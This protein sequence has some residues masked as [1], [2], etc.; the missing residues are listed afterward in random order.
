M[1]SFIVCG[2]GHQEDTKTKTRAGSNR[3]TL[4]GIGGV[5]G[6]FSEKHVTTRGHRIRCGCC[7]P[8]ARPLKDTL[9]SKAKPIHT[10]PSMKLTSRN[11]KEIICRKR[12]GVLVLFAFSGHEQAGLCT[13]CNERITRITG[14]RLHYC[15]PRVLGGSTSAANRVLL[16]PECHDKVHRQHISISKSRLPQ[17]GVR[18]T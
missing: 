12:F 9:R 14:W 13:E 5:T 17:R 16:H 1:S 4:N 11:A 7:L 3:N 6:T 18:R 10:I 2:G 15:V 8:V